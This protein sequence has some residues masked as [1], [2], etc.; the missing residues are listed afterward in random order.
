[1]TFGCW[2]A[3]LIMEL[4]NFRESLTDAIRYWDPRRILYNVVLAAIVLTCFCLNYPASREGLLSVNGAL[5]IFILAVLANV[6]YCS[7]YVADIFAQLSGFRL[8]WVKYR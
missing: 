8:V 2:A 4:P 1:M 5:F 6:A 7:A 3:G